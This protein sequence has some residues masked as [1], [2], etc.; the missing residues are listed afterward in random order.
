[1]TRDG[2][3]KKNLKAL[4]Q[5]LVQFFSSKSNLF[6]LHFFRIDS[7][8]FVSFFFFYSRAQIRNRLNVLFASGAISSLHSLELF[9]SRFLFALSLPLPLCSVALL[10]T[11]IHANE[12]SFSSTT[13]YGTQ[14][15]WNFFIFVNH[16]RTT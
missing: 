10:K 11:T 12:R 15:F 4:H 2:E 3:W 8:C 9:L 7:H 6:P 14:R 5:L 13:A 1:M 16:T